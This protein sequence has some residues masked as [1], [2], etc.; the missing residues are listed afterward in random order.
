KLYSS[1]AWATGMTA[2]RLRAKSVESANFFANSMNSLPWWI[3]TAIGLDLTDYDFGR[4]LLLAVDHFFKLFTDLKK[5]NALGFDFN[6]LSR[7][8]IAPFISA[9]HAIDKGSKAAN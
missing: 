7:L 6:E 3:N 9:I 8:G 1:S 2:A 5:W 4:R